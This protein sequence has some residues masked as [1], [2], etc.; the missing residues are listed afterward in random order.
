VAIRSC[1]RRTSAARRRGEAARAVDVGPAG[2]TWQT[3]RGVAGGRGAA[4]GAAMRVTVVGSG[5]A[6]GSG[7]R[8]NTCLH[9]EGARAPML[10]DC[11]ASSLVA[12][13]APHARHLDRNAVAAILFTH[14]HGDHF[15]GLPFFVL[16]AQLT[17][18]R[19]AALAIAGPCGV[20]ARARTVMEAIFPGSFAAKRRFEMRFVEISPGAPADLLG[21]RVEA[22]AMTHD[23]RA[24]PCQGYRLACAG[25]T[26]AYSGDTAWCDALPALTRDADA[27]ILECYQAEAKA[28]QAHLDAPTLFARRSELTARRLIVTHMGAAMLAQGAPSPAERAYDGM[29]IDL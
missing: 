13:N 1:G 15:G 22:F 4:Q 17:T 2:A 16:D 26:F 18:R 21:Y 9:V 7:G 3:A 14:F 25:K 24:G 6:F 20:E 12:L 10:V 29:V 27:A 19:T 11:G 23:E 28:S 5:D 8:F